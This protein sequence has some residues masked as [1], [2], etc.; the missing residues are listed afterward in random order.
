MVL[1]SFKEYIR[2]YGSLAIL[3]AIAAMF[4]ILSCHGKSIQF[5]QG[6]GYHPSPESCEEHI[7]QPG[8]V[9][10]DKSIFDGVNIPEEKAL[11]IALVLA[12][13]LVLFPKLPERYDHQS[14]IAQ[15]YHQRKRW[16]WARH[17]P[18][19]SSTFFPY[20]AAVRDH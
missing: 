20:F 16:V 7:S 5:I 12:V 15:I 8:D 17:T 18:F 6:F 10:R 11:I 3:A 14:K 19:S 1:E 13:F 4:V 2:R 9:H